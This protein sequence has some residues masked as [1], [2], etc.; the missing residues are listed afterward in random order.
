M[1]PTVIRATILATLSTLA[2]ACGDD[3]QD[4]PVEATWQ[5]LGEN[6]PSALLAAWASSVDDVWIVGGRE[7]MGGSPA[8]F[9]YDGAAW[10]KLD[11]GRPNLDVWQVFGFANGDV[12]LGGSN[13][14]ILR[15]R[16]GAFEQI[17]TPGTATVFGIWGSS[18]DDVWAVGGRSAGGAFVWRYR[19]TA[20][21][22]VP[23][24]PDDLLTGGAVWKVTG[25]AADDVWMSASRSTVLRWDGQ[26]LASEAIGPTGDS[27][28]SIGCQA[29]RCTTA[30]GF[31]N[32][33]LYEN[34]G[35]GWT[36]KVPTSDGPVW[37]GVTPTAD[38]QITVGMF[39]A[40]IRRTETSW[41]SE[42]HG[43]TQKPFHAVWG[44]DDGSVFAVGGDFDRPLTLAGVLLFKGAQELPPLP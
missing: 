40:V 8:V 34:S 6:R 39:G 35:S 27:L 44:T 19:G 26:A 22:V 7:G 30:G 32:G 36:S 31:T 43:L 13:G 37:R 16:G 29:E 25:R 1:T 41:V 21:E 28:F 24:V 23:G 5:L 2:A 11:T 4:P 15:Y 33:V 14:T 10:T 38:D 20:F 12:F 17:S 3:G 18:P 42:P 9:H